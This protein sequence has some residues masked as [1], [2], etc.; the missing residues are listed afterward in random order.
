MTAQA[1]PIQIAIEHFPYV[2]SLGSSARDVEE[3][4][5][6]RLREV[7]GSLENVNRVTNI[8]LD[9]RQATALGSTINPA[10]TPGAADFNA[11]LIFAYPRVTGTADVFCKN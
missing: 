1:K 4:L 11:V 10:G 7:C 5:I 3:A 9:L 2:G 6:T 8:K